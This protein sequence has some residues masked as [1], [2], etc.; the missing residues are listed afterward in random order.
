MCSAEQP[1]CRMLIKSY[2]RKRA[3]GPNEFG[4]ML[5]STEFTVG[6]LRLLNMQVCVSHCQEGE[7]PQAHLICFCL[8][9]LV[10]FLNTLEKCYA[11][12]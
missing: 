9:A 3:A 12:K 1:F 2:E 7:V 6:L 4:K 10:F 11:R 8:A 5:D